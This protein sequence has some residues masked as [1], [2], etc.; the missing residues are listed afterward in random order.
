M[1][2]PRLHSEFMRTCGLEM[3]FFQMF[4]DFH[5]V[6]NSLICV[7]REGNITSNI[8]TVFWWKNY[9]IN[10][11]IICVELRCFLDINPE[12]VFCFKAVKQW[13]RQA[14][15][16]PSY[17]QKFRKKMTELN[18]TGTCPDILL[19]CLRCRCWVFVFDCD[20]RIFADPLCPSC[21][22]SFTKHA[23]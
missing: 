18:N 3:L 19:Q 22:Q 10:K 11:H 16:I 4:P 21:K 2:E 6:K 5:S 14:V 15:K 7:L 8:S 23:D 9:I 1:Y 17:L 12:V 13:C 20:C